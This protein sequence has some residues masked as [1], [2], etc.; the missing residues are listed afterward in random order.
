MQGLT[1]FYRDLCDLCQQLF[2]LSLCDLSTELA[3]IALTEPES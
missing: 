2:E 1:D 3:T